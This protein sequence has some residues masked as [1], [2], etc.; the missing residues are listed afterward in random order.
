MLT[1]S[2]TVAR[3]VRRPSD[4]RRCRRGARCT[5]RGR[6]EVRRRDAELL[7]EVRHLVDAVDL[8]PARRHEE[9]ADRAAPEQRREPVELARATPS[10]ARARVSMRPIQSPFRS[11]ARGVAVV[12]SRRREVT[13]CGRPVASLPRRRSA[14]RAGC[15]RV[16]R[17]PAERSSDPS[18]VVWRLRGARRRGPGPRRS[19]RAS[20]GVAATSSTSTTTRRPSSRTSG[21]AGSTWRAAPTHGRRGRRLAT[22]RVPP[23][24]PVRAARGRG[25]ARR[26]RDRD[27][28]G[29]RRRR[30]RRR[31][32]SST[33]TP[34][35]RERFRFHVVAAAAR[36]RFVG[37]DAPV[38]D[39]APGH[40][41]GAP[42]TR[43]TTPSFAVF[44]AFRTA[45]IVRERRPRVDLAIA[46]HG[47]PLTDAEATAWV[48][49]RRRR[50]RRVLRRASRRRTP[51]RRA[52]GQPG[53]PTRGETL[54]DGG[55]AVLV[56]AP[57]GNVPSRR[58]RF[59][60]T[61]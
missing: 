40:L 38:V 13:A 23:A 51:G 61:G 27:R 47:L 4:E 33:P 8:A 60:T 16:P 5:R 45:R 42:R 31:R 19:R 36:A 14:R 28:L 32:G 1:M 22:H 30:R 50:D 3:R 53:S 9:E 11:A 48:E 55:P 2:G 41:R 21:R 52:G 25:E 35:R 12:R 7:E 26:R 6:L 46:P 34:R 17:P 39:G 24:L 20:R 18:S 43:S 10:R 29:G 37:G 56:R 44:G 49:A 59:A 58:T 54:G 15:L 57:G